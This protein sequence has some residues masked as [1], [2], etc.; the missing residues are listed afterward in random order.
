[1]INNASEDKVV[2][3]KSILIWQCFKFQ[4][5][6]MRFAFY[7][8]GR[9]KTNLAMIISVTTKK[10][11][12][13]CYH[14]LLRKNNLRRNLV[15]SAFFHVNDIVSFLK[16]IYRV[17]SISIHLCGIGCIVTLHL[18]KYA[19]IVICFVFCSY[20]F[21]RVPRYLCPYT[22]GMRYGLGINDRTA[23]ANEMLNHDMK[24][25][26]AIPSSTEIISQIARFVVNLE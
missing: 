1:M 16:Y 24:T 11:N 15:T 25:K 22:S 7:H 4:Y 18:P 10:T 26:W 21:V 5:E 12:V 2:I 13:K 17:G 8:Q 14:E 6:S 20:I 9:F 23:R 3:H 19:Q